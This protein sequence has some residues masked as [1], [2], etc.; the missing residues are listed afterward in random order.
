MQ[1][2]NDLC[3]IVSLYRGIFYLLVE[4]DVSATSN[5]N[6]SVRYCTITRA[7]Y[8]SLTR[9]RSTYVYDMI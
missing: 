1:L 2:L 5:L 6:S 3:F 8:A 9:K 4:R 7:I